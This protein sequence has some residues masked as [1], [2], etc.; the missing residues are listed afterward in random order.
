[1]AR[2]SY[3]TVPVLATTIAALAY[4]NY[5]LMSYSVDTSP[6]A[7]SVIPTD[8]SAA[9]LNETLA[10]LAPAPLSLTTFPQTTQQPLFFANRRM[11]EKP[12]PKP[13]VV[14]EAK[15]LA[16]PPRPTAP[17]LPPPDPLQLV[18][19]MG[20]KT[21]RQALMRTPSDPQGRWIS[22]GDE[23]RGWRVREISEDAAI[24]EAAGQQSELRL[25]AQSVID[26][27]NTAKAN[28]R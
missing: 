6:F 25:Y 28:K 3:K 7:V 12:K 27:K 9:N 10:A 19:I 17:A 26:A 1:M 16:P 5:Y 20:S 15:L 24:V 22:A 8:A 23:Y 14:V 11:P 4:A 13:P 2:L 21:G 18:G